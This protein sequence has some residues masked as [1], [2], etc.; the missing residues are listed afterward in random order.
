MESNLD[1]IGVDKK[2]VTGMP[3]RSH[4][5]W[6]MHPW[7]SSDVLV[8]LAFHADAEERGLIENFTERG[9][10]YWTFPPDYPNRIINV[11]L[12]AEQKGG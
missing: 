8:Q 11:I 6:Y 7:V 10:R 3:S 2:T 12:K 9:F 5:F 4:D 1:V